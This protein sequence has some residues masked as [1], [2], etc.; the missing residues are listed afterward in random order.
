MN[1]TA[2]YGRSS[3]LNELPVPVTVVRRHRR[4]I[5]MATATP[6]ITMAAI[7][8]TITVQVSRFTLDPASTVVDTMEEDSMAGDISAGDTP[9]MVT[10]VEDGARTADR[11]RLD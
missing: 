2:L 4:L 10:P 6:V 5:T 9:G 3:L 7:I 11:G 1:T 8:R